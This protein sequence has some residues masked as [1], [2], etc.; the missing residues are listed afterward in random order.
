[1]IEALAKSFSQVSVLLLLP[2]GGVLDISKGERA[3][4]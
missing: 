1:M 2:A 4:I 3:I